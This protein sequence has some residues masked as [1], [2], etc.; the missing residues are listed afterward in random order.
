MTTPIDP[1]KFLK[2][3]TPTFSVVPDTT[4]KRLPAPPSPAQRRRDDG[5]STRLSNYRETSVER[6]R[7]VLLRSMPRVSR[8]Q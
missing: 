4:C 5:A 3:T 7:N 2:F 1:T 8:V 6:Q